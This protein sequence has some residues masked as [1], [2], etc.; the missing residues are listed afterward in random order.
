[1]AKRKTLS[2]AFYKNKL[3]Q[4]IEMMKDIVLKKVEK[5]DKYVKTG[6]PVDLIKEINE[7]HIEMIIHSSFG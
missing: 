1:L 4:M 7:L 5:W 6:E 2:G 3:I